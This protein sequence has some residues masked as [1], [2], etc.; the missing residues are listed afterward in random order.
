MPM[1]GIMLGFVTD[2]LKAKLLGGRVDR[3]IQPESD[4]IILGIRSQ[5]DNYRLLL[6]ASPRS[7][8]AHL[9][10]LTKPSPSEPPMFCMLLRK[11]LTGG[12]LSAIEQIKND[13]ILNL[14]F[15][16]YNDLGD[17]V[18]RSL[19]LEIMGRHSNLILVNENNIILDA[20]KHVGENISSVR[21]VLP[22]LPYVY[23]PSRGKLD[24]RDTTEA[25]ISDRLQTETGSLD[26]AIF[27]LFNGFSPVSALEAAYRLSLQSTKAPLAE[28]ILLFLSDLY[29]LKPAVITESA[30]N[31]KSD[32][33]PFP[34]LHLNTVSAR[35]FD[36]PSDAL[37]AFFTARDVQ[38]HLNQRTS[39]MAQSVKNHLERCQKKLLIHQEALNSGEQMELYKKY[40]ELLQANLHLLQKGA[41]YADVPDYYNENLDPI[42]IPMTP[43]LSPAQN[44]QRYFKLYRKS[45]IAMQ[46]AENECQRIEMDIAFLEQI[47]DDL[48]KVKNERDINDLFSLLEAGGYI[49]HKAL[50]AKKRNKSV[51]SR[52][53]KYCSSDGTIIEVGKNALQNEQL[54]LGAKGDETWLHAQKMPGSHV[55]IHS[56][57]PSDETLAQAASL[58]AYYSKGIHSS[59]VPVDATLRRY[60]KKPGGTPVGYVIYTHQ[61]TL[62]VTPSEESVRKMT[63]LQD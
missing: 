24:P 57:A 9:T 60:V 41:S 10:K 63:C 53:M 7:A 25:E 43:S 2:E 3:I 23:P 28:R 36:S 44:A 33:F 62:Y 6:S 21:Q 39:S 45:H 20:I 52:P 40:G 49:R 14:E 5:G 8:R 54:T 13:R 16:V 19:V 11:Q 35:E 55:I 34:Q 37:D 17:A 38:E 42:R 31:A 18:N 26:E 46:L 15:S 29:L 22:G 4:E 56:S 47:N 58:A 51:P 30:G 59:N 27:H 48:R 50:N 32:V 12:R 1:D 61:K